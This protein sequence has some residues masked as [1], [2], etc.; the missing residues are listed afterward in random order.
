[1]PRSANYP[2]D[3]TPR[4]T[5]AAQAALGKGIQ[6][7]GLTA[8]VVHTA[9]GDLHAYVVFDAVQLAWK[10]VY[11]TEAYV[12]LID[13][14]VVALQAQATGLQTSLTSLQNSV[15]ALQQ[16]CAALVT[17]MDQIVSFIGIVVPA[18]TSKKEV[19]Q[20]DD[21][22]VDRKSAADLGLTVVYNES[23]QVPGF[24][25]D[26]VVSIDPPAGTLVARGATVTVTLD[27]E[28]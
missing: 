11:A 15:A 12:D 14:N 16:T 6:P 2:L 3:V 8:G 24:G 26:D 19:E 9:D 7:T 28:G 18:W 22:G 27:I 23:R 1:M 17:S 5:T 20:G 10:Q 13:A 21:M 4:F 25:Q